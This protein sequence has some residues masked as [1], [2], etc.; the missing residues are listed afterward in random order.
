MLQNYTDKHAVCKKAHYMIY[1]KIC[2]WKGRIRTVS[3]SPALVECVLE[4]QREEFGRQ[5]L[6]HQERGKV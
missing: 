4:S 1:S 2:G 6:K 5:G 3:C